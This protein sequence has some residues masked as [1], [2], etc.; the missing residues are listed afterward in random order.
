MTDGDQKQRSEKATAAGLGLALGFCALIIGFVV[1][2][3]MDDDARYAPVREAERRAEE[4]EKEVVETQRA[5]ALETVQREAEARVAELHRERQARRNADGGGGVRASRQRMSMRD[6]VALIAGTADATGIN[7]AWELNTA[8]R[9]MARFDFADGVVRITCADG[10][11][12]L[13]HS[14]R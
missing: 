8:T 5:A 14:A 2:A 13:S 1:W 9:K 4:A 6:C 11:R 3:K 7:P 10:E 12:I